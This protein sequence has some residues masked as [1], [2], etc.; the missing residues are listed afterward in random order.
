M[1]KSDRRKT[2]TEKKGKGLKIKIDSRYNER[3]AWDVVK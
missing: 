3:K 2:E 1:E